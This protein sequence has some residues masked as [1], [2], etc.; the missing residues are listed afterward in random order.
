MYAVPVK[1]RPKKDELPPGWEKHEVRNFFVLVAL[2]VYI[3]QYT[4]WSCLGKIWKEPKKLSSRGWFKYTIY[5]TSDIL[6]YITLGRGRLLLLA[7]LQR[8]HT[9]RPA[10]E[11]QGAGQYDQVGRLS[12]SRAKSDPG[13]LVYRKVGSKTGFS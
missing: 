9:T 1:R 10:A 4:L 8:H 13:I 11:G 3:M 5:K 6:W 12:L 2:G 7:H